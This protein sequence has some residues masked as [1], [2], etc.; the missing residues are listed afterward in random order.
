MG[1]SHPS[2]PSYNAADSPDNDRGPFGPKWYLAPD[3]IWAYEKYLLEN[4][5]LVE[6]GEDVPDFGRMGARCVPYP[7]S[8]DSCPGLWAPENGI[9]ARNFTDP[10]GRVLIETKPYSIARF[11]E[12]AWV[13]MAILAAV[14][15]ILCSLFAGLTLGV[16]SLDATL[17]QLRCI[18]GTPRERYE[19]P[20]RARV[21]HVDILSGNKHVWSLG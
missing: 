2:R 11:H 14:L 3:E 1:N 16:C 4:G 12:G 17:L 6:A 5:I 10:T 7:H 9:F 15:L 20:V 8:A 18:T 13:G 19:V 21:N